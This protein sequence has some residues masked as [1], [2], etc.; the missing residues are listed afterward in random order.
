MTNPSGLTAME[1]WPPVV[2]GLA[3]LVFALPSAAMIGF[4]VLAAV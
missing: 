2:V 3:G 1:L 4:A